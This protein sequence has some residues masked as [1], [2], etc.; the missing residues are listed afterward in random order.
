MHSNNNWTYI[1]ES[2]GIYFLNDQFIQQ[3]AYALVSCV[4]DA[5]NTDSMKKK[6][7][8]LKSNYKSEYCLKLLPKLISWYLKMEKKG[9]S[10][11]VR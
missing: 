4:C 10:E 7:E 8:I 11:I 6:K 3:N 1:I 9:I 2:K 5:V